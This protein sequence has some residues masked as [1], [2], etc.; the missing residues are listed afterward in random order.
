M[1]YGLMQIHTVDGFS[2]HIMR[3]ETIS[4]QDCR[5]VCLAYLSVLTL[6]LHFLVLTAKN[7]TP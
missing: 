3:S 4:R 1:E 7:I 2:M 5:V 6:L